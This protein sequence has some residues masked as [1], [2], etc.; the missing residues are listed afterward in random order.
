MKRCGKWGIGPT[1]ELTETIDSSRALTKQ[2]QS[3][4]AFFGESRT[5]QGCG[6]DVNGKVMNSNRVVELF[7]RIPVEVVLGEQDNLS[8]SL[9]LVEIPRGAE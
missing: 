6:L 8:C 1:A 2:E 5:E 9:S 4:L 7:C 3:K